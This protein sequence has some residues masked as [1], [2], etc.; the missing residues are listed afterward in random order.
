MFNKL[1]DNCFKTELGTVVTKVKEENGMYWHAFKETIFFKESGGMQSDIGAID[2]HMVKGLKK[3][4]GELWHL[5]DDKLEGGVFMSVNLHERFRKCQVHTAQHL[6]SAVLGSVYKV[7]TLAHHVGDEDNDIEFDLKDFN[8]KMGFELEVLCNGLIRDDLDVS[9]QYPNYVEACQFVSKEELLP[10]MDDDIRIVRIGA[11]DYNLCGCMHVP[12]LRYLQMLQITGFEKTTKG[13]KI[14]Y[15]VGDQLLDSVKKRYKVLDEASNS[16]AVSHLYVNTGVNRLLNE[17]KQLNRDVVVWKQKYYK[18]MAQDLA[19]RPETVI[20][21]SFDD[22]DQKSLASMAQFVTKEDQ[23]A[24]IFIAKIYD[25][26]HVVVAS[27]EGVAF[28]VKEVFDDI[29]EKYHLR[30]GGSKDLCQGGG[31]FKPEII[32]YVKQFAK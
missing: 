22:I 1:Y 12:S 23:K 24:V 18:M 3:E 26:V 9:V 16:L 10:H 30:G 5:L 6:I 4:D 14:R 28:Q 31:L 25:N 7:K 21:E 20:I 17:V 2:N 29:A 11:L 13:Y 32:D 15:T 27:H 8:Q 19:K